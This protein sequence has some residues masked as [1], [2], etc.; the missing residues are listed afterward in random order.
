MSLPYVVDGFTDLDSELFNPIIDRIEGLAAGTVPIP[1]AGIAGALEDDR[2]NM[3]VYNMLD[4]GAVGDGVTDDSAAWALL[5]AA[6]SAGDTVYFPGPKTYLMG[7]VSLAKRLHLLLADDATIQTKSGTN[8][9]VVS[10]SAAGSSVRGGTL[11]HDSANQ[12]AGHGIDI[13]AEGVTI[14]RVTVHDTKGW[15]IYSRRAKTA[16]RDC[17]V[18]DSGSTSIFI[19]TNS[20]TNADIDGCVVSGNRIDRSGMASTGSIAGILIDG[21]A[22]GTLYTLGTRVVG[23]TVYL[24]VAA[25][26]TAG[27]GIEITGLADRTTVAGNT[28]RGGGIGISI[29]GAD[30]CSVTGNTVYHAYLVGI[31]FAGCT[32][33]VASGNTVDGANVCENGFTVSN[34]GGEKIVITGNIVRDVTLRGIQAARPE[35]VI[36]GNIVDLSDG[37]YGIELKSAQGSVISGNSVMGH[38]TSLKAIV[39]EN[40]D[41]IAITGNMLRD[42]TQHGVSLILNN[43]SA[44]DYIEISGNIHQNVNVTYQASLS[45]GSTMGSNVYVQRHGTAITELELDAALNH[46]GTEVGFYGATPVAQQTGVAVTAAGVHAALVNLGLIT[47]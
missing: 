21:D 38:S 17:V 34:S 22:V 6:T 31:E 3:G 28:V 12:S 10:I 41:E 47:A 33:G 11:D 43:G 40:T 4:Y 1:L 27:Q 29:S 30:G 39:V 25:V 19:Q 44:F 35:V 20:I 2:G 8:G 42:F 16:I 13:T 36:T 37:E 32:H 26:E 14:E 9:N 24:P 18:T 46:D 23:N 7:T 15:G 5:Y 45:G